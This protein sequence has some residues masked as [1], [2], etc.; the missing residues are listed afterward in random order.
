MAKFILGADS[1]T[2]YL[3]GKPYTINKQAQTFNAVIKGLRE[4]DDN[5]VR[6]AVNIRD[7]IVSSLA[8]S[9]GSKVRIENGSIFY[10]DREVTGLV[11]SRVFSMLEMN[12][13]VDPMVRFI[14]N[15]MQNP[16][17]RAVDE[18]FGFLDACNL[19]ITEDGHFLAYKRVRADYKD[20]HSGTLDN[21]VGKVLSMERNLVDEDKN[22][23]CSYGLHFCSYSYLSH[24]G[25]ERIVVLKINPAD[26]VA[27]PADY[28]NSKGRTCRYEVVDE[29]PLNKYNLPSYTLQEDYTPEYS[30]YEEVVVEAAPEAKVNPSAKL[31]ADSV[32]DIREYFDYHVWDDESERINYICDQWGISRRQAWRIVRREAWKDV[33]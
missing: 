13:S 19:P 25:G 2:V 6:A 22:N 30:S 16:S 24:F 18:L 11:A 15:L 17:K 28:N 26:V 10:G 23:T 32:S 9:A 3:D 31:T 12:L 14:E 27:I 5:A 20:C 8:K 7:T 33:T 4:N 21:S 29:I 1:V